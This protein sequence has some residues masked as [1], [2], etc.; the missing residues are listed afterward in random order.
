MDAPKVSVVLT[1]YNCGEYLPRAIES[2]LSQTHQNLELLISDDASADGSADIASAYAEKDERVRL[3]RQTVNLG[4][5]RNY[6]F[7]FERCCG[8]LVTFQ[9]A[10]DWSD[11]DRLRRQVEV[12]ADEA[13]ALCG[14][15]ALFHYPDGQSREHG[16]GPSYLLEG[17]PR[18]FPSPPPSVLFRR[19]LLEK[20]PGWPLYFEGG[21]S[22]DRYFMMDLLD[23]RRGWHIG[24]PLYHAR[25][26][27]ASSHRSWSAR[28]FTTAVLFN[29]LERQRRETG[30]DW[31]KDQK[32]TELENYERNTLKEASLRAESL[33]EAAVI[34][35]DCGNLRTAGRLLGRAFLS[36]PAVPSGAATLLYLARANLKTLLR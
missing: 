29:E 28:K 27:A 16:T 26:R 20:H 32:L 10:D 9:D 11:H 4:L 6:N 30:T 22:M 8:D 14:T 33:R 5:I 35:I 19:E 1:S 18:V 34:Q 31:L 25:V 21:T 7:L 23:G 17:V 12:L 15:G 13:F 3:F 36:N 2:I 24:E